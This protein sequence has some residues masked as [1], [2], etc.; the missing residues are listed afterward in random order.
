M[1]KYDDLLRQKLEALEAS[2]AIIEFKI[3]GTI[4]RANEN[5]EN[6]MG[7]AENELIGQNHSILVPQSAARM[8]AYRFHWARLAQGETISAEFRRIKKSG[9]SCWIHGSYS[10]VRAQ[11]GKIERV[12]KLASNVTWKKRRDDDFAG[13]IAA[14]RT[15]QAVVEFDTA[16]NILYANRNYQN[17][18]GHSIEALKSMHHSMLC[19]P[20]ERTSAEYAV[21]WQS[22]REGVSCSILCERV[23]ASGRPVWMLASYN[24]L[25]DENG[26]VKKIVKFAIDQTEAV[27]DHQRVA[28]LSQ[29]DPLT[30][31]CNRAGFNSLMEGALGS[32]SAEQRPTLLLIDLDGFKQINDTYGHAAGDACLTTIAERLQRVAPHALGISR[33]G[34]DEFALVFDAGITTEAIEATA[35]DIIAEV[36]L[37][38]Q[39]RSFPICAG[40][41][42]GIA[43]GGD[44]ISE[45]MHEA[46]TALYA[47]KAAGRGQFR[48]YQA[49]AVLPEHNGASLAPFEHR[50]LAVAKMPA[51]TTA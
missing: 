51:R 28:Y 39:W 4:L 25:R 38:F 17:L 11:D 18:T 30:H 36:Q 9:A 12:I 35:Q 14:I 6:L 16:G 20:K 22:L 5:F 42:I 21:F 26:I 41:S 50:D 7:Y 46:D 49:E 33:L 47:A 24:P 27:Q 45:I 32:A 34:G 10:P 31:L 1:S 2:Y 37:P 40:A 43:S 19:T 3:D 48:F 23:G 29:H 15:S 8:A 44:T 13:Q